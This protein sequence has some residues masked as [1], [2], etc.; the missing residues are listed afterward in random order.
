MSTRKV[1]SLDEIRKQAEPEIIEIPG[2]RPGTTISVAVQAV[3]LTPYILETGI[4]NPLMAII[5]K[6]AQEGKSRE[7]IAKEIEKKASEGIDINKLLPAVDALVE[8]ALVEPTYKE[9]TAIHKLTLD[10]KLAIF[11]YVT[12]GNNLVSFRKK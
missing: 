3:D 9:I 12:G 6:K 1:T 2:F 4:S 10:Q 11:D 8:E 7:E 5:Q